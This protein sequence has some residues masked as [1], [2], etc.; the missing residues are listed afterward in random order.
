MAEWISVKDRLPNEG[1]EVLC[2][3]GGNLMNV[4]IYLDDDCWEDEYGYWETAESEG[5]THWMPLP[6]PPKGE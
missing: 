2:Y 1:Q 5:I 3:G 6:E 4:Y